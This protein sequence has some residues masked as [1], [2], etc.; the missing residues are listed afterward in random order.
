MDKWQ[1]AIVGICTEIEKF[2]KENYLIFSFDVNIG[3]IRALANSLKVIVGVLDLVLR[4]DPHYTPS[5]WV[6]KVLRTDFE[7]LPDESLDRM[8]FLTPVNIRRLLNYSETAFR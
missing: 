3:S 8:E 5:V 2:R 7:V 1:P 6:D 4:Y